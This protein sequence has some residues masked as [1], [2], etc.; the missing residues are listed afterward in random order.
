MPIMSYANA[1]EVKAALELLSNKKLGSMQPVYAEIAAHYIQE[2]FDTHPQLRMTHLMDDQLPFT[3]SFI[4]AEFAHV[5][6]HVVNAHMS[7]PAAFV[8]RMYARHNPLVNFGNFML[9]WDPTYST[10]SANRD[11]IIHTYFCHYAHILL[12]QHFANYLSRL[13]YQQAETLL[14]LRRFHPKMPITKDSSTVSGVMGTKYIDQQMRSWIL[15]QE[16]K[17]IREHWNILRNRI[18]ELVAEEQKPLYDH[19][20]IGVPGMAPIHITSSL[21]TDVVNVMEVSKLLLWEPLVMT[22][23]TLYPF[24]AAIANNFGI[25]SSSRMA[26]HYQSSMSPSTAAHMAKF[27]MLEWAKDTELQEAFADFSLA[28][29]RYNTVSA[30]LSRMENANHVW[31]NHANLREAFNDSPLEFAATGGMEIHPSLAAYMAEL[32]I[33]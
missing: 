32:V 25:V 3:V 8:L 27:H 29:S 17:R 22:I 5:P 4:N 24:G 6:N 16:A 10:Y 30:N 19:W 7:T 14:S 1:S 31:H 12:V 28:S 33:A 20:D 9:K 21:G 15:T 26:G 11:T 23:S 18:E 2:I 13:T